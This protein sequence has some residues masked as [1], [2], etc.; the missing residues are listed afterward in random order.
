MKIGAFEGV[1][2]ILASEGV[3]WVSMF[4]SS[5]F[6]TPCGEAGIKNLMMRNERFAIAVAD[7]YSRV[8]N[9]KKFGVCTVQGGIIKRV[10]MLVGEHGLV[11]MLLIC[12]DPS[13]LGMLN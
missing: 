11:S 7:A 6:N 3:E 13:H 8:S 9:G 10:T 2:K 12:T 4:P 5:G 1:V